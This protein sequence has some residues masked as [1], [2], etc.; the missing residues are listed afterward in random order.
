MAALP[1]SK[2]NTETVETFTVVFSYLMAG[3]SLVDTDS[4]IGLCRDLAVVVI[5]A[6]QE[7]PKPKHPLNPT[8]WG[9]I[10]DSKGLTRCVVLQQEG[11]RKR[12]LGSCD[13]YRND[14]PPS[15]YFGPKSLC[16]I[17]GDSH[18]IDDAAQKSAPATQGYGEMPSKHQRE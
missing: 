5:I 15:D 13:S 1:S 12:H 9:S 10:L 3:T 17:I 7:G 8:E 11:G 6:T 4:L 16:F 18:I 14:N 2:N